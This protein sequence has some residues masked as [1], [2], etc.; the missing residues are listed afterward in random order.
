MSDSNTNELPHLGFSW[1]TCSPLSGILVCGF[2]HWIIFQIASQ[3]FHNTVRKRSLANNSS[4]TSWWSNTNLK[5]C[6]H[7]KYD[8][9]VN[10]AWLFTRYGT[11][12]SMIFSSIGFTPPQ[13]H[14]AFSLMTFT[15]TLL[16]VYFINKSL[17]VCNN[18][19]SNNTFGSS[20]NSN[21]IH[22]IENNCTVTRSNDV[23]SAPIVM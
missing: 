13:S 9:L 15:F 16:D 3:P 12:K 10:I 18:V 14:A 6:V 1:W 8:L 23:G 5:S 21:V 17:V 2:A 20:N 22:L 4:T 7:W 11:P 19:S